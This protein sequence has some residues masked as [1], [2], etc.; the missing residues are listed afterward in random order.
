MSSFNQGKKIRLQ[1]IENQ[2]EKDL[3][4]MMKDKFNPD[5]YCEFMKK[6]L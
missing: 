5:E 4:L 2:F 1:A 3:S 6:H